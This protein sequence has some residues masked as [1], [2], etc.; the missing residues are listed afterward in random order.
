[1]R[2]REFVTLLG[3][4]VSCVAGLR[5]VNRAAGN[6]T[7]PTRK[8]RR[9][10]F[11]AGRYSLVLKGQAFDFTVS[12]RSQIPLIALSAPRRRMARIIPN[13]K[14]HRLL[15]ARL[16]VNWH[17]PVRRN[18]GRPASAFECGRAKSLPMAYQKW[19]IAMHK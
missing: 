6:G 11:P 16:Q 2:R 7:V 19:Y 4:S 1:M 15:A 8:S 18:P 3:G 9:C 12:G 17:G 14:I 13:A 10:A 5:R